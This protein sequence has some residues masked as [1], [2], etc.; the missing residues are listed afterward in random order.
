MSGRKRFILLAAVAATVVGAVASF[1]HAIG[2]TPD[3]APTPSRVAPP[4]ADQHRVGGASATY[5]VDENGK[6]FRQTGKANH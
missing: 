3:R 4:G 5:G 6:A 1:T 2:N